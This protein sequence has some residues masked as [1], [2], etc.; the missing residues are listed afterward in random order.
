MEQ[1]AAP[2]AAQNERLQAVADTI[3]GIARQRELPLVDLFGR[4]PTGKG[5]SI[6]YQLPALI[7]DKI[8]VVVSPLVSLMVD[9][10]AKL[11]HTVGAGRAVAPA[12]SDS[13][14]VSFAR[15]PLRDAST[16][17]RAPRCASHR[18]VRRPSPPVP[19]VTTWMPSHPSNFA[20]MRTTILPVLRPL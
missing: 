8:T 16:R 15:A 10:C 5:K 14:P 3:S 20:A 11:N 12:G 9:Q 2:L 7:A 1:F 6:T 18:P 4:W 19:P 17:E 13:P